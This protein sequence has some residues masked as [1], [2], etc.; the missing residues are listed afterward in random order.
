MKLFDAEDSAQDL[1][2]DTPVAD[3]GNFA[4]RMKEE[5]KQGNDDSV[6]SYRK[7]TGDKKPNFGGFK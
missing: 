2:D 7:R 3:K 1:V 4:S 5:Q 6:I